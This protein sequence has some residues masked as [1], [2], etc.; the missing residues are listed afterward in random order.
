MRLVEWIKGFF[1]K[2]NDSPKTSVAG[3]SAFIAALFTAVGF[4]F[5]GD[6]ATVADWSSVLDMFLVML[7]ALNAAD[8]SKK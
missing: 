6:P 7:V 5:D 4:Q 3:I 8:A 2:A 1:S